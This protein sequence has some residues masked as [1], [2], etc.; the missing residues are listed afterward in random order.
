MKVAERR[1]RG[2]GTT[3]LVLVPSL[4][5]VFQVRRCGCIEGI[6]AVE[7]WAPCFDNFVVTGSISV[8]YTYYL[9]F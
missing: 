9:E 4:M 1:T 8:L 3:I 6:L 2:L 5:L 7:L